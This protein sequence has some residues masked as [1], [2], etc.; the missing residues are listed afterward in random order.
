MDLRVLRVSVAWRVVCASRA[1]CVGCLAALLMVPAPRGQAQATAPA[2]S[3]VD[4]DRDGLSDAVEGA[5]LERFSPVFMVSREDC[6]DKPAEFVA[7]VARP[8][9]LADDG[10]IYGQAFPRPGQPG[11]V[12][13]HY[14]HLWRRDCGEMGHRLD[15]EH[16]SV[17][18]KTGARIADAKAMYWYA[19]SHEDTIC[20]ASHLAR[21]STLDAEDHGATIWI[22]AGKHASS[23]SALMC[24]HGCG[25][26]QCTH[27][28]A[29]G[30]GGK[31]AGDGN[32]MGEPGEA[33]CAGRNLRGERGDDRGGDRCARDGHGAGHGA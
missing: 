2:G 9:V 12:E 16:A 20:D 32:G 1:L 11:E 17:L 30:A 13:L 14:Y 31:A 4:S 22:S 21:A 33:P 10:T 26:D 5:L 29:R 24:T 7:G 15:A 28:E 19:A 8:T 3:Q 6:S 27:M 25:G 18:V 23:L